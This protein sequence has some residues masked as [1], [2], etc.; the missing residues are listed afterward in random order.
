MW[1]KKTTFFAL[2]C[3]FFFVRALVKKNSKSLSFDYKCKTAKMA[4]NESIITG[5]DS[6]IFI[7]SVM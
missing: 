1:E 5:I 3:I 4:E 6:E 7:Y 2:L